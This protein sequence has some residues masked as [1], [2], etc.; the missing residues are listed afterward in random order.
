MNDRIQLE[1]QS[2]VATIIMNDGK[3]NAMSTAMLSDISNAFDEAEKAKAVTVLAGR[4][5]M[6]SAGFDLKVMA[7]GPE[8]A[9]EM[10]RSGADLILKFLKHPYPILSVCT[11]H[12]YPMGAF[13]LLSSDSRIGVDGPFKIGLNEPAIGITVPTFAVELTRHRLTPHGFAQIPTATMFAPQDAQQRGYLD[14]VVA[15]EEL[16]QAIDAE[17]QRLKALDIGSFQRTK[18]RINEQVIDAVQTALEKEY[19]EMA[20]TQE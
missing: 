3:V 17:T 10:V 2:G 13:L 11:G 14:S 12:A 1:I 15:A 4:E 6:F 16:S 5:G 19:S 7:G 8:A 18:Q 9:L 20:S